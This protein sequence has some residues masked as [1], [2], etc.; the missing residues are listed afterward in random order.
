MSI[1]QYTIEEAVKSQIEDILI[2]TGRYKMSIEGH[3]DK[4]YELEQTLQKA[5]KDRGLNES[6]RHRFSRCLL[7][8]DKKPKMLRH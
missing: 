4:S 2:I 1:I 3:F 8:S 7:P 6:E 5:G